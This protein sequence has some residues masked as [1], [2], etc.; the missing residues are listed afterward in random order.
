MMGNYHIQFVINN[1]LIILVLYLL[2]TNKDVHKHNVNVFI[3][4]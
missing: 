1:H 4:S 3:N 2:Y